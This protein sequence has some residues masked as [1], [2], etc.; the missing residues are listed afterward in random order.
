MFKNFILTVSSLAL[1][2][3][4]ATTTSAPAEDN[5]YGAGSDAQLFADYLIGS[6]TNEIEDAANRAEYYGRAYQRDK[7][8]MALARRAVTASFTAGDVEKTQDLSRKILKDHPDEPMSRAI[9]GAEAFAAGNYKKANDYFGSETSDITVQILMDL[10]GAWSEAATGD[11]EA[12]QLR[13][14]D[15]GG[16]AYFQVLSRVMQANMTDPEGDL[17]KAGISYDLADAAGVAVTEV[18]LSRARLVSRSGEIETALEGLKAFDDANGNFESGPVRR[19]MDQLE[20]GQAISE[21]L[22]P[23][24]EASWALTEAAYGFFLRN[25]ARDAAEVYIRTALTLDPNNDKAK[26]WLAAL[27]EDSRQDEALELF[28]SVPGDSP[29]AVS[30]RLSEAN[31]FFDREEDSK[32]MEILEAANRDYPSFMTREALGRARLIRENYK[33]ALPIYD[34]LVKSMSEE[35]LKND[36][37]PLYFRGICYEREKRWD[38]AV[39]DFQRVLE[40]EPDNPDA[41]NYLGYTWVDRGENLTEAF[42]MIEKAVELEP[43]SGAIVDSLGWAHYKLGRYSEARKN[44]EKAVELSPNSA[45]IIDHL[46][47]VYWKLGRFRE[48]GYQWERALEYD[49]TDEERDVIERKLRD[50]LAATVS[51]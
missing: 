48:A 36:T 47:D 45:T 21:S 5:R 4:C 6:Y 34:A 10:M 46:G 39:A 19:Y 32:A 33:D 41:L 28:R 17:T 35:E 51:N 13:L 26:I 14:D 50:G 12:A 44:L 24:Q 2:G 27:I 29:Y 16:A 30:A 38:E 23:Q 1:L 9:L 49:P 43:R 15:L 40:I 8:N 20:A 11:M 25:R 31:I 3:A 37:Q 42:N 22:T 7:D 18:A